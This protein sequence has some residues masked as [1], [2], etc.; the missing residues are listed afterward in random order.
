M[1]PPTTAAPNTEEV[2]MADPNEEIIV[3][4][5]NEGVIMG[6]PNEEVLWISPAIQHEA[7]AYIQG[8]TAL[9]GDI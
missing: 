2:I 4:D 5:L 6:D 8:L 9:R 3:G 1:E 7:M